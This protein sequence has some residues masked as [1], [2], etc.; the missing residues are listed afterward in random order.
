M[1]LLAFYGL[2]RIGE[3]IKTRRRSL[4]LPRDHMGGFCAIFVNLEGPKTAARGGPRTQHLRVDFSTA[5]ELV[6][7]AVAGLDWDEPVYPFGPSAYRRRWDYLL[8]S[9]GLDRCELTPGGLR[10]GG[11]VWAYHH[12]TAIA[13][14]QWRMRLKHQHT[15]VHYLQEVAALNALLDA[16][17]D[18]RIRLRQIAEMFPYVVL[19]S[20]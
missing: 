5:V 19:G 4:L 2:A 14:I 3:V 15:L 8:S 16:G 17:A 13:D 9:L 10:G 20:A 6:C 11:A 12:G 7:T 18:A 1:T